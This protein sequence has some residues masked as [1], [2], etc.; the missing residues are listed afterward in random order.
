MR[1]SFLLQNLGIFFPLFFL[2]SLP[3]LLFCLKR[4]HD[5]CYQRLIGTTSLLPLSPKRIRLHTSDPLK[6]HSRREPL[7]GIGLM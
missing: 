2:S 3:S 6:S 7:N 5:D 4:A 1:E